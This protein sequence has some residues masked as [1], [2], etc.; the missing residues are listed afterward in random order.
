[1]PVRMTGPSTLEFLLPP[2]C[3]QYRLFLGR[4]VFR[5]SAGFTVEETL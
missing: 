3:G 4:A 1:M 2:Y 5:K